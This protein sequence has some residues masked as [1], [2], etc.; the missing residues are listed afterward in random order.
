MDNR[1]LF[2]NYIYNTLYQIL[3]LITP[4]ITTPYISRVL[5][6][7][8]IGI[9]QFSQSI[10]SYFVL[11]G[12]MGTS[13][14][15]Q[16]E[17][18]YLQDRV[19]ERSI[20]FWEIE[21]FRIITVAV[22]LVFYY[23]F[24]CINR[25]YSNIYS[26]LIIEV[27]ATAFDI[28]WFYMGMENFKLTVIRNTIIKVIGI[29][30]VFAFIK[31]PEDIE[32]YTLCVSFPIL[33]GNLSLWF[34]LKKHLIKIEFGLHELFV[35]IIKRVKPVF[36]LFLPQIAVDVYTVL[37]KTM[38][39]TLSDSIDE[40]GYYSQ[41]QKIIKLVLMVVTSLGTVM[42]P[43]VSA[44]YA[45]NDIKKINDYIKYSFMYNFMIGFPILLGL[46]AIARRFV[47]LFFG[48]G[49]E[50]VVGLIILI[51]P[52]II[53]IGI[54]NIIGRQYLLPTK[55]QRQFTISIISGAC[56]NFLFNLVLIPSYNAIGASIATLIAELCVTVLQ[57]FFIRKQIPLFSYFKPSIKYMVL[58]IIMYIIVY[59][60]GFLELKSN[61]VSVIFLILVGVIIY[62]SGLL[63]TKDQLIYRIIKSIFNE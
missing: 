9:Y 32:K 61:M 24:F 50:D 52:V 46:C 57:C 62:S 55:R 49:Y 44:L 54:S 36:V 40:V 39:G 13:L 15:G 23:F 56:I 59:N 35:G 29:I 48:P 5:G 3:V 43:S 31:T 10:A 22:S 42:L 37:D 6:V 18:A 21:T 60:I 7:T 2:R 8:N 58:S 12:A 4:L 38:I 19:K 25:Q 1:K 20:A 53:I 14:Y 11:I 34:S 26:I 30:A 63:I 41:A 51:S 27:V 45:K 33:L 47:P 16:R 17:I 28:S